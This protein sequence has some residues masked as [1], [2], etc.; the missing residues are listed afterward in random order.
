MDKEASF[1]L[2]SIWERIKLGSYFTNVGPKRRGKGGKE[3]RRAIFSTQPLFRISQCLRIIIIVS[4]MGG[5]YFGAKLS[6]LHASFQLILTTT[7]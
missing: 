2:D 7:L 5:A 1:G 3:G 4:I 6:I